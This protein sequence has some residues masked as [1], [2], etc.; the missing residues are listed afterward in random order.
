MISEKTF[1]TIIFKTL[2]YII[3][4]KKKPK[5]RGGTKL[6]LLLHIKID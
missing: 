3:F 5:F 4:Q 2:K 1:G 6:D